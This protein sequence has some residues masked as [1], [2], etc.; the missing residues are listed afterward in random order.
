MPSVTATLP[1]FLKY[2]FAVVVLP[3]L[4]V[5]HGMLE[6]VAVQPPSEYTPNCIDGG[7]DDGGGLGEGDGGGVLIMMLPVLLIVRVAT[8]APRALMT[9]PITAN[10]KTVPAVAF[11]M[12]I[13]F[14]E[15]NKGV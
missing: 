15:T 2:I 13:T 1:S 10:A 8:S 3:G 7:G 6:S 5:P 11:R 9:R 12:A 14:T 4:K